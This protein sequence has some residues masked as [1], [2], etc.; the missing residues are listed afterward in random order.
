M[1]SPISLWENS[2][3]KTGFCKFANRA[4]IISGGPSCCATFGNYWMQPPVAFVDLPM[5]SPPGPWRMPSWDPQL[6]CLYK[7]CWGGFVRSR[8]WIC[9]TASYTSMH[10]W[11]LVDQVLLVKLARQPLGASLILIPHGVAQN[12]QPRKQRPLQ[13]HAAPRGSAGI[14]SCRGRPTA[15][16]AVDGHQH[17]VRWNLVQNRGRCGWNHGGYTTM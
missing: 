11:G 12:C 4:S 10:H 5:G 15:W 16:R 3:M 6:H 1:H 9:L 14:D 13:L 17:R 8:F 2:K 7:K